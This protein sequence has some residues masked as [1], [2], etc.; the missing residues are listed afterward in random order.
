MENQSTWIL[1]TSQISAKKLTCERHDVEMPHG[2]SGLVFRWEAQ[3]QDSGGPAGCF[4]GGQ[5]ALG[6]DGCT[7]C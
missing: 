7:R 4:G 3:R 2:L 5:E 1:K 6:E